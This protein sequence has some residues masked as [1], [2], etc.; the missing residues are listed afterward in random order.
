MRVCGRPKW[1]AYTRPLRR[2][3]FVANSV[4]LAYVLSQ[5]TLQYK[6]EVVWFYS[7]SDILDHIAEKKNDTKLTNLKAKKKE[8][9][10]KMWAVSHLRTTSCLIYLCQKSRSLSSSWIDLVISQAI[11]WFYLHR[12]WAF[13][14]LFEFQAPSSDLVS[15]T[16]SSCNR[17]P[18]LSAG[19]SKATCAWWLLLLSV[20]SFSW[21]LSR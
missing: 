12:W 18:S 4:C 5:F 6:I 21:C 17:C 2:P 10:G 7:I 20:C 15:F 14:S 1:S 16:S 8:L 19:M 3:R 9:K 11:P 13:I